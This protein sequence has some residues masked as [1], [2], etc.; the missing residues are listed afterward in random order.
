MKWDHRA[1]AAGNV[2]PGTPQEDHALRVLLQLYALAVANVYTGRIHE[3]LAV[4]H[5]QYVVANVRAGRMDANKV[6]EAE[7]WVK[8]IRYEVCRDQS[9]EL[10]RVVN[11]EAVVS[12]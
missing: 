5:L 6:N 4:E 9:V 11:C 3:L 8:V 2:S 1:S 10:G 12:L 7:L